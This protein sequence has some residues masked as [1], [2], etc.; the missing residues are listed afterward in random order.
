MAVRTTAERGKC[1]HNMAHSARAACGPKQS[2]E[3]L[4]VESQT[5]SRGAPSL[6]T[7]GAV[8]PV[9]SWQLC[10]GLQRGQ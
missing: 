2:G 6:G 7:H 1:G 9:Y 10:L 5:G 4:C 8:C 3:K